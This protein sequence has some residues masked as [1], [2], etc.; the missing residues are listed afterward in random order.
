MEV[1][2]ALAYTDLD[3]TFCKVGTSSAHWCEQLQH[4]L[5]LHGCLCVAGGR[6]RYSAEH[7][8]PIY[9][10]S[11]KLCRFYQRL[12]KILGGGVQNI[13]ICI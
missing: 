5:L 12:N 9:G 10:G 3:F 1:R 8:K 7:A 2:T 6:S 13:L 4:I 11:K